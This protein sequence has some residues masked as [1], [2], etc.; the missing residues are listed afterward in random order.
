MSLPVLTYK[1]I[2]Y[3]QLNNPTLTD[4]TGTTGDCYEILNA[5]DFIVHP[6]NSNVRITIPNIFNRDLGSGIKSWINS[7]YI[8]YDGS[9]WQEVGGVSGGGGGGVTS[10]TSSDITLATVANQT[11]TPVITI[12]AAPKL[13]IARTINGAAFD[14][15][16][17]ITITATPSGSASGDLTGTYPGPSIATAAVTF[18][19]MANLSASSKLIGRF[20][21]GAGSPQE[22]TISTGLSLDGSGN[23]TA[24][25]SGGTVTNVVGTLNRIVVTSGSTTPAI[26]I[27]PGYIG[28]SSITTLGI[29][30]TGTWQA[31]KVGLL[32]GGTNANL[33]ATG[34]AANYLKQLSVGATI[35]VG[36]ILYTDISGTP[37]ALPPSGFAGGDLTGTYPN[38]TIRAS[39]SLTTPNINVAIATSLAIGGATIGT[40]GLA[41]TGHLLLEGVT[42]TGAT[43]TGKLVFDTSPTFPGIITI[44]GSNTAECIIG[45]NNG[46]YTVS[47]NRGATT[48]GR[49]NTTN[50]NSGATASGGTTSTN[51]ATA[52]LSGSTTNIVIGSTAGTSA[53]II[54]GLV[55]FPTICGTA[56]LTAGTVTVTIT[57]L[58]TSSIAIVQLITESGTL[59]AAYKAPCTSNTLT[60]T[61]VTTAGIINTLDTSTVGYVVFNF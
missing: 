23:L 49:T 47:I 57:G 8:Y 39:V 26:D 60:I 6:A 42:S 27:D 48:T 12:V 24:T 22:I 43:G 5:S 32:Y 2:W 50:I 31:T 16:G 35:T 3:S 30:G 20:S 14:G 15:T 40:N 17:N 61:S 46:S 13:Q 38:P 51:I 19:K 28:Q 7:N 4:N 21:A 45:N 44:T 37:T 34:G 29:I 33:S 18:A 41:V 56:T 53:T 36:T 52:G 10:V 58:T 9:A 55:K 54:N 25:I 11:T 1:G 59:A